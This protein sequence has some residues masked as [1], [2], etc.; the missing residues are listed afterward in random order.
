MDKMLLAPL[1]L[2]ARDMSR[3]GKICKWS[4]LNP[5]H[6][7]AC[8]LD[9][10]P[11]HLQSVPAITGSEISDKPLYVARE[12]LA[13]WA[14]SVLAWSATSGILDRLSTHLLPDADVRGCKIAILSQTSQ[15]RSC[16]GLSVHV[17]ARLRRVWRNSANQERAC[18][19]GL[20]YGLNALAI[21]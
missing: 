1:N 17:R 20:F 9:L 6:P 15:N 19:A 11:Q 7:Q 3:H 8:L 21:W 5:L 12:Y 14:V 13:G 16:W 18:Q 2:R 4:H 10:P